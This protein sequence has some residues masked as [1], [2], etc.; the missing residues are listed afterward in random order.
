MAGFG[1]APQ[2]DPGCFRCHGSKLV[3]AKG[4]SVQQKCSGACHDVITTDDE[5]PE[6]MDVLFPF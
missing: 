1:V 5:K 4:D 2:H 3:N 6:A